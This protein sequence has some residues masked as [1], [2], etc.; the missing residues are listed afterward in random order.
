LK[1]ANDVH[2]TLEDAPP[3]PVAAQNLTMAFGLRTPRTAYNALR[4]AAVFLEA[5]MDIMSYITWQIVVLGLA[6]LAVFLITLVLV[7][8]A[9][10]EDS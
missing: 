10:R 3:V 6:I 7:S 1:L 4:G 8:I 9:V 5:G 2:S